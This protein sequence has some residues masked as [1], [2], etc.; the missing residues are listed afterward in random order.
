MAAAA[1]V[2]A[3]LLTAV[4]TGTASAC[5]CYP[6]DNESWRYAR[7]NHVF[8]GVVT[9]KHREVRDPSGADD[10]FIY[11]VIVNKEYKGDVPRRVYVAT[12]VQGTACG[13]DLQIGSK[14]LVFGKG[15]SSDRRVESGLCDGTRLASGGPPVTT[16]LPTSTTVTPTCSTS[17]APST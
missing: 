8:V 15:D 1:T 13:I 14:Y 16:G 9:A 3:G 11:T 10:R 2:A 5:S 17:T 7:A 6:G 12:H 4:F